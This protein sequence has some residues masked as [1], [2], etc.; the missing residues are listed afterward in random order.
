[1]KNAV[2]Y[3]RFSSSAQREESIEGQVR[4]CT[5]R[6]EADGYTIVKIYKDSAVSGTSVDKRT[7][8][9][10]MIDDAKSGFFSRIYIYKYDRF[11]R[12]VADSHIYEELLSKQG[13]EL[14]SVREGVPEGASGFLVK[15]MHELLAQYYSVNLSE[16]VKRGHETNA[17][18]CKWNG[19]R[20]YGYRRS[21]DG[22]FEIVEDEARLVRMM[23]KLFSNGYTIAEIVEKLKPYTS[24][25]KSK[26][27]S[28]R[29]SRILRSPRYKGTYVYDKHIV[30]DAIPAIVSKELWEDVNLKM[31]H[32]KFN[33][34]RRGKDLYPLSCKLFD[35]NGNSYVGTSGTS[36][37]GKKYHYYLNTATKEH[38]RQD[39]IDEAVLDVLS[40]V[41]KQ[42]NEI[43][44]QIVD[45]VMIEQERC[46]EQSKR[47][48]EVAI[49]KQKDIDKQIENCLDVICEQGSVPNIVSRIENLKKE[50][51][52][53][54][55]YIDST[56]ETFFTRE[57]VKFALEQVRDK[58][59]PQF[60]SDG[61][62]E[63]VVIL[64]TKELVITFN[65]TKQTSTDR[66]PI[67][68]RTSNKWWT[69]CTSIR[70]LKAVLKA[71]KG[72]LLIRSIEKV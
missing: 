18:K 19:G 61:M 26:W 65:I 55:T 35:E 57:M 56:K 21:K 11:A 34:P 39:R 68:V 60:L 64:D 69:D 9:L 28:Q 67:E 30:E 53:L 6:A 37:T 14:V 50:R 24:D 27:Y 59:A 46:L 58:V 10:Q 12:N 54:D 22:Y 33:A 1:M 41:L 43:L 25:T 44:E 51:S 36:R 71:Y 72:R 5:A 23:Y 45:N 70:T 7:S 40:D 13:V 49:Q 29:V 63:K 38:V 62:I 47:T 52:E 2:I 4:E 3:A 17:L 8:F 16:N 66:K 20:V 42:D 32:R 15:G 31:K 48:V